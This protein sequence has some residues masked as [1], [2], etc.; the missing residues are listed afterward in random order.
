MAV[1]TPDTQRMVAFQQATENGAVRRFRSPARF[2]VL[3]G[4]GGNVNQH[5]GNIYFREVVK[6]RKVE[7]NIARKERKAEICREVVSHV[8]EKGGTFLVK[9]NDSSLGFWIEQSDERTMAKV[10]QALREG[11]PKIREVMGSPGANKKNAANRSSGASTRKRKSSSRGQQPALEVKRVRAGEYMTGGKQFHPPPSEVTPPCTT[12]TAPASVTSAI[13]PLTLSTSTL[14]PPLPNPK[15]L[16]RSASSISLTGIFDHN[17]NNSFLHE[18]FV[19]PF[20]LPE[21]VLILPAPKL[22]KVQRTHS[23]CLSDISAHPNYLENDFVN[24]FDN[25]E[26]DRHNYRYAFT[27]HTSTSSDMGGL[28]SLLHNEQQRQQQQAEC[29]HNNVESPLVH[30]PF[31]GASPSLIA[32]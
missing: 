23:L 26:D 2:D 13:P 28:G 3:S 20:G 16:Q 4:R 29:R 32:P 31:H 19:N 11:A 1:S 21:Q 7:Y 25:E 9:E 5:F 24:P 6:G 30:R 8:A 27:R 12:A 18:D 10:S 17:D 14:S 15:T 22:Q